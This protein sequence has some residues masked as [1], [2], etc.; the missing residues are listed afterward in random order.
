MQHINW[1]WVVM[2]CVGVML[3]FVVCGTLEACWM[4]GGWDVQHSL[5][6]CLANC[7]CNPQVPD[8]ACHTDILCCFCYI[9]IIKQ[10]Q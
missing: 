4:G 10:L 7:K 2:P 5:A 6:H 8:T 1:H 9:H 3:L